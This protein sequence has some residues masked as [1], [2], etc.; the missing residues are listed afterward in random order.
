MRVPRLMLLE[1]DV[2]IWIEDELT[3]C[4][5]VVASV[6]KSCPPRGLGSVP[7][8]G[9]AERACLGRIEPGHHA[10]T[11]G[12]ADRGPEDDVW[13]VP[14]LPGTVSRCSEGGDLATGCLAILHRSQT[15]QRQFSSTRGLNELVPKR[16]QD[17]HG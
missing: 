4:L 5:G 9:V 15:D 10:G 14:P 8:R 11:A 17:V 3:G 13:P 7:N 6:P 12:D 2:G 1:A 16:R